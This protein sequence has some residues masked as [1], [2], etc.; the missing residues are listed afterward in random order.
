MRTRE[1]EDRK[2]TPEDFRDVKL[3]SFKGPMRYIGDIVLN[4]KGDIKFHRL[5]ENR[6]NAAKS[7]ESRNLILGPDVDIN[8]DGIPDV[9][10]YNQKG[11]P[12]IITG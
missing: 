6:D 2:L 8:N 10:L 9:V 4:D 12:V 1:E 11:E 3:A 7:A 5:L